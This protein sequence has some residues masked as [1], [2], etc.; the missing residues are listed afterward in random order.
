MFNKRTWAIITAVTAAAAFGATTVPTTAQTPP[1]VPQPLGDRSVFTDRVE[2]KFKVKDHDGEMTVVSTK[3]ASRTAVVK[4]TVQPGARSP[5]HTH[6]GPVVVNIDQ[7]A[8]TYVDGDD[9]HEHSYD[10]GEAFADL[11]HGHVHS[12][13]N[14]GTTETVFYATFFE[15]PKEGPLSIPAPTP[16]CA[17]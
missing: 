10:E 5:W 6:E 17:Q 15:V 8:L 7:G 16:D 11:G 1:I 4:F 13:Y 12:T 14:P 3:D 2:L 9:C